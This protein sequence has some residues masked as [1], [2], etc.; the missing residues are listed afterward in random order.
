MYEAD[1]LRLDEGESKYG[2][3]IRSRLRKGQPLTVSQF[4][5]M[6]EDPSILAVLGHYREK[7][8]RQLAALGNVGG[9]AAP[10]EVAAY[11]SDAARRDIEAIRILVI[12]LK[13]IIPA[14]PVTHHWIA[15]R[16]LLGVPPKARKFD[17]P[18]IKDAMSWCRRSRDFKGWWRT[19]KRGSRSASIYQRPQR[20]FDL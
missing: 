7:A 18:R 20:S 13:Q 4:L 5:A 17:E 16:L 10:L 14:E 3:I 8:E 11:I 12:W 9:E 19:E 1:V 2:A 15:V 6:I